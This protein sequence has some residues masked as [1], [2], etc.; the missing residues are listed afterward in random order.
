MLSEKFW[1]VV[2]WYSVRVQP[3]KF[4][5][6]ILKV[7]YREKTFYFDGFHSFDGYHLYT[8]D[9]PEEF[10][11]GEVAQ[12]CYQSDF[13]VR[14]FLHPD[15]VDDVEIITK[16]GKTKRAWYSDGR[17]YVYRKDKITDNA[18]VKYE[19][20]EPVSWKYIGG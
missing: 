12:Y 14:V 15:R 6:L 3:R 19:G 8:K 20:Y 10:E 1:C 13:D 18:K 7:S 11:Q 9:D 4:E 5:P 16:K 17:W 2:T